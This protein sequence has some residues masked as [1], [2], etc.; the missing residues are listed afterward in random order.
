MVDD[1]EHRDRHD[2]RD[3]EPD[4]DVE[5]LVS[6][7]FASVQKKLTPKTTQMSTTAMLMRPDQFGV[8]L[9][10]GQAGG[11]RDGS[12]KDDCLPAPEV[13][14]GEQVGGRPHLAQALGGIIDTGEHHVADEGE[15]H[16]VGVERPDASEGDVGQAF[17]LDQA[18]AD[19]LK[20]LAVHLPPRKLGGGEDSHQHPDE[21]PENGG[22]HESADAAIVVGDGR[23]VGHA[24]YGRSSGKSG[25]GLFGTGNI[26]KRKQ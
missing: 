11:K 14:G 23:G 21:A 3:V 9:A 6:F 25:H 5:R 26:V 20:E 18:E 17:R 8:F 13:D 22:G 1:V 2:G 24:G 10:A 19:R 7:R 12:S 16:R 4:G 15:D